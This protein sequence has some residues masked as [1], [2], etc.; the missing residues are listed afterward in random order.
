MPQPAQLSV[1]AGVLRA[2]TA[3]GR[4]FELPCD[5][6]ELSLGGASGRMLYCRT[7]PAEIT[8]CSED[9]RL[10]DALRAG[11]PG[12][13]D[14]SLDT[15]AAQLRRSGRGNRITAAV[16]M[17]ALVALGYGLWWLPTRA[18][19]RA[20]DALPTTVDRQL[21]DAVIG[22]FLQGQREVRAPAMQAA[23]E[24]MVARL[25][26][27]T[28]SPRFTYRVHVIDR[29]EMNA[30]ALPGGQIVV[31]T[32]LIRRAAGPEQVAGVLAHEIAH[33]TGRHGL[34]GVAR[35]VGVWGGLQLLVGDASGLMALATAGTAHA[36]VSGYSREQE[37]AA[38]AEGARMMAAAG[39]DPHALGQFFSVMAREPRTE[40]PGALAWLSTHPES[41]ERRATIEQLIPSLPSVAARPL[42]S[43]WTAALAELPAAP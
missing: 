30:F 38:D 17:L 41:E 37:R 43:D 19:P 24:E 8:V 20:V 33:V 31:F 34:R 10:P 3:D 25:A 26:D 28:P 7:R 2:Q 21:G 1:T 9:P 16:V 23:L 18:L 40:V 12:V 22:Q 5:R 15:L 4:V 35:S 39:L 42:Q 36:I 14:A 13:L 27:E 11:A 32:G 29:D 6:L